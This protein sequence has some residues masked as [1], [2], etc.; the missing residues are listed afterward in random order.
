MA[1]P[2][3]TQINQSYFIDPSEDIYS[4]EGKTGKIDV[5]AFSES[6]DDEDKKSSLRSTDYIPSGTATVDL[7]EETQVNNLLQYNTTTDG[8]YVDNSGNAVDIYKGITSDLAYKRNYDTNTQNNSTGSPKSF[9]NINSENFFEKNVGSISGTATNISKKIGGL[10]SLEKGPEGAWISGMVGSIVSGGFPLATAAVW[11]AYGWQQEKDKNDFIKKLSNGGITQLLADPN[12]GYKYSG[13]NDMNAS[14]YLNHILFNSFNPGYDLKKYAGMGK[15]PQEAL[16][17]FM[18]TGIDNGVFTQQSIL[19]MGSMRHDLKPG[20]DGYMK[21]WAAQKALV[22]KGWTGKGRLWTDPQ[23]NQWLDGNMWKPVKTQTSDTSGTGTSGTDTSGTDSSSMADIG[24]SISNVTTGSSGVSYSPGTGYQFSG[25]PVGNPAGEQTTTDSSS[26]DSSSSGSDSSGS[27]EN[28]G[29]SGMTY[30]NVANRKQGGVVRLQEG[31]LPEQAMMEQ[32]QNQPVEDTGNLEMVSEPNKD[33]SGVAD[34]VPRKLEEGDFVINA[35]AVEMAGRGDIERMVTKAITELQRKGVKL[36]FGTTAQDIDS[37]VDTLVSNGEMIIPKAL[38]EQIGYDRLE[39]INNRGK[40]R[41][42][43]K[44]KEQE[45]I[46]QNPTQPNPQQGMMAVGGQ[47]SLDE[48]KNQPIAVPQESF[49]GQSS[50]G[51]KLLSPMSPEAQDDEKELTNRSQSFEGFMKPIKLASGDIVKNSFNKD[52]IDR[53]IFKESSNRP[54]IIVKNEKE[55]SVGLMQVGQLALTDV[56]K[57]YG[58]NYKLE[59]L[60]DAKI[61]REVGTNYLNMLLEKYGNKQLALAAYNYGMKNVGK[62]TNNDV[63]NFNNLPKDVQTYVKN[64]LNIQV[65]EQPKTNTINPS[66]MMGK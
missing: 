23:G 59:Q 54:D 50:V 40:E 11:M 62:D 6:E 38:A 31:G 27:N 64:I 41:V 8:A 47:V 10:Y 52:E 42:E 12:K 3:A 58:T 56:N 30:G 14:Q 19:K 57:K 17:N 1:L 45:Q 26:S 37:M 36:D 24:S 61:N 51:S 35:P 44:E 18:N 53:L 4:I 15:S 13:K 66:G 7:S 25:K 2:N 29:T 63:Q 32:M 39:K 5:E 21:A 22:D 20:S 9:D 28:V 43:A 65:I 55:H 46:Q 48:N 60:T 34:D 16:A 49:A 33:T